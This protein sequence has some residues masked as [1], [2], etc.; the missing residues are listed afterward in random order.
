MR[1]GDI[2]L[3]VRVNHPFARLNPTVEMF[4]GLERFV[5][6]KVDPLEALDHLS[7]QMLDRSTIGA[8]I[9]A[10]LG[11]SPMRA[12]EQF[13]AMLADGGQAFTPPNLPV[14]YTVALALHKGRPCGRI[15]YFGNEV[16]DERSICRGREAAQEFFQF[17]NAMN[18]V[19]AALHAQVFDHALVKRVLAQ[20][21]A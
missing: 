21:T 13:L 4:S 12:M 5:S 20:Q 18:G 9:H 7:A 2:A 10:H 16:R 17:G 8:I 11:A 3:A 19:V 14:S 15:T 1:R 6:D